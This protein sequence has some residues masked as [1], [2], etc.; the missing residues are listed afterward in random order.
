LTSPVLENPEIFDLVLYGYH[1]FTDTKNL[2][3]MLLKRFRMAPPPG[4]SPSEQEM[5][6]R[7]TIKIVQIRVLIFLQ[8]WLMIYREPAML[9][10]AANE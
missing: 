6:T 4:M 1:Y 9:D 5:F 7:Q 8:S 3:R 10:N 2:L